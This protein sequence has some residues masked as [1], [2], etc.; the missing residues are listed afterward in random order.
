MIIGVSLLLPGGDRLDLPKPHRHHDLLHAFYEKYG[1][2]VPKGTIQGFYC[3]EGLFYT[4]EDA[5]VHAF[6]CGQVYK[7]DHAW[8]LFSE[9]VW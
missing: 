8:K 2:K 5:R 6:N 3:D 1:C 9:D 4:R 7:T